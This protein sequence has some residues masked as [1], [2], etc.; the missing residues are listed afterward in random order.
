MSTS[1]ST[2]LIHPFSNTLSHPSLQKLQYLQILIVQ[3]VH[4]QHSPELPQPGLC[5][6]S[7]RWKTGAGARA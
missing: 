2:P 5:E 4:V 1:T 7:D 6:L 3:D